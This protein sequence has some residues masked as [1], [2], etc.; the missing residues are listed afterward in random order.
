MPLHWSVF[1]LYF[2]VLIKHA[3]FLPCRTLI[4]CFFAVFLQCRF[5]GGGAVAYGLPFKSHNQSAERAY[6]LK[7]DGKQ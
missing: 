1:F 7:S 5:D 3:V 6:I 2:D 4:F